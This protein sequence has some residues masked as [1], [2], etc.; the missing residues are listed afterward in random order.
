MTL[1]NKCARTG[2]YV[3]IDALV[4]NGVEHI[5]VIQGYLTDL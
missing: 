2:A 4:Q 1:K 5:F 3:L